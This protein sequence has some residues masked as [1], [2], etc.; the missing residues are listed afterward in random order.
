MNANDMTL[1]QAVQT[2]FEVSESPTLKLSKQ[3]HFVVQVALQ[4]LKSAVE[5][6]KSAPAVD[7]PKA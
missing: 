3:E 5:G 6:L 4:K 1:D 2:L 7:A